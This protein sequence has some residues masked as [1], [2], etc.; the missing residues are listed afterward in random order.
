MAV[1]CAGN[2]RL[3]LGEKSNLAFGGLSDPLEIVVL[4]CG[5]SADIAFLKLPLFPLSSPPSSTKKLLKEE[6]EFE[7]NGIGVHM[8]LAGTNTVASDR[9]LC[10][11]ILP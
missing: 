10:V 1:S 7:L 4:C 3:E 11:S 8:V 2:A 6:I 9:C 5:C